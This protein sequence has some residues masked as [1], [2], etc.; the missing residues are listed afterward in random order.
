MPITNTP[1]DISTIPVFDTTK[2]SPYWKHLFGG[3]N[4]A[5]NRIMRNNI[6]SLHLSASGS[7]FDTTLVYTEKMLKESAVNLNI[8]PTYGA[9]LMNV[10]VTVENLAGHKIPTGIPYR[11]MWLH[12]RVKDQSNNTVFES[13]NWDSQGEIIGLDS[14]YEQHYSEITN[15]NQI[16]IYEGVLKDVNGNFTFNLL[17]TA[18]YLK[19]NRLPPKGFNTSHPSYDTIAIIGG[20]VSDTNFNR[21]G[22]TQ[23]TGR[24]VVYYKVPALNGN[25]Y[26]I[27]AELCY[28]TFV[29]RLVNYIQG[30][31]SPDIQKFVTLYNASDKSPVIM[32][33]VTVPFL[34]GV[35][36][37]SQNT[38]SSFK[39]YQNYPNP[40]NPSTKIKFD[41]PNGNKFIS[42]KI[43]DVL[44]KEVQTLVAGTL[45]PGSYETDFDAKNL[46]SGL[47]FC[48]LR[49]ESFYEIKRMI[50]LK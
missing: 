11:R 50:Y 9:G 33:T 20:A 19:D 14:L 18:G 36:N 22:A 2:R 46:T 29:P 1:I 6:D 44:G 32:K 24:D 40:F 3:G 23:G 5:M 41:V 42:M 4:K 26:T 7:N 37:I 28:Q 17:R 49:S 16:Q 38:P 43:Y 15:A 34:T 25:Q 13:G 30:I 27:T 47:Y 12:F 48:V 31:G 39:L 45:T 8:V 10:G 35:N 21:Q